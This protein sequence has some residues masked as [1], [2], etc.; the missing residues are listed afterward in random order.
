MKWKERPVLVQIAN[1][2]FRIESSD[3]PGIHHKWCFTVALESN[4]ER[5]SHQKTAAIFQL[6]SCVC[7][8]PHLQNFFVAQS[9]PLLS[10]I[11]WVEFLQH[12]QLWW[13]C[14]LLKRG[15]KLS[16][17]RLSN[18]QFSDNVG[19][20]NLFLKLSFSISWPRQNVSDTCCFRICFLGGL[21]IKT[22]SRCLASRNETQNAYFRLH[23]RSQM[24]AELNSC[25]QSW[26]GD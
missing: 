2:Q 15:T 26:R 12:S 7:W 3:H 23:W 18:F 16:I 10:T 5:I 8:V 20:L 4:T 1:V 13:T 25:I 6:D 21:C 11:K 22:P 9:I 24:S 17:L 14:Q 19:T